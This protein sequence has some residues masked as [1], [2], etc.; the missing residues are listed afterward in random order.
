MPHPLCPWGKYAQHPL[1]KRLDG[2]E[3]WIVQ[4]VIAS[5]ILNLALVG[6]E[7]IQRKFEAIINFSVEVKSI[8]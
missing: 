7:F 2:P 1:N 6:G 8:A 4:P 3:P 5:L